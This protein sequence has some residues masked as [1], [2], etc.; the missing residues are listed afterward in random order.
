MNVVVLTPE[1]FE[2]VKDGDIIKEGAM[3]LSVNDPCELKWVMVGPHAIGTMYR[4]NTK[5]TPP[6]VINRKEQKQ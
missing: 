1:G 6:R 5:R 3:V 4:K 2:D